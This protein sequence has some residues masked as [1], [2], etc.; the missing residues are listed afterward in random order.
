LSQTVVEQELP[1][2]SDDKNDRPASAED[3]WDIP[4]FLRKRGKKK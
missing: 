4:A 2:A 3:E 1:D